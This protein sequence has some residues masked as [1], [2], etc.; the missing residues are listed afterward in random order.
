MPNEVYILE[1]SKGLKYKALGFRPFLGLGQKNAKKIQ[2]N[3]VLGSSDALFGIRLQISAEF[4]IPDFVAI[5]VF[6]QTSVFAKL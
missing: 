1:K 5:T 2:K 3:I 6:C 4:F